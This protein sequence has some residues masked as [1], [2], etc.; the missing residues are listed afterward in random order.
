M[1][2]MRI[3]RLSEGKCWRVDRSK[4]SHEAMTRCGTACCAAASAIAMAALTKHTPCSRLVRKVSVAQ[5]EWI[6]EFKV[7]V[8]VD[9]NVCKRGEGVRAASACWLI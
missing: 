7:D 5:F 8:R 1:L 9:E 6:Y 2:Q 3:N 4:E